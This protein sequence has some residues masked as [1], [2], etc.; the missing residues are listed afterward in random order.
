M[1]RSGIVWNVASPDRFVTD[2]MKAVPGTS[3][4]YAGV[5][6]AQQRADLIAWLR[7]ANASTACP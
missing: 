5:A 3:M 2:P 1:R 7:Q 6:D 4:I